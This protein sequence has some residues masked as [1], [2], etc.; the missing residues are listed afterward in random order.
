MGA[1]TMHVSALGALGNRIGRNKK[2]I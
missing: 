2:V 1:V